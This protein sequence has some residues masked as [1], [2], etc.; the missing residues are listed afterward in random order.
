MFALEM[1]SPIAVT[2]TTEVG[3]GWGGVDPK[4][5]RRLGR[6]PYN[7]RLLPKA[8]GKDTAPGAGARIL[9]KLVC[10]WKVQVPNGSRLTLGSLPFLE[11]SCSDRGSKKKCDSVFCGCPECVGED[12]KFSQ[13]WSTHRMR[14]NEKKSKGLKE[15]TVDVELKPQTS[16]SNFSPCFQGLWIERS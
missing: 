4:L 3:R 14:L 2:E 11:G 16:F 6:Q 12:R 7:L 15:K 1:L 8:S 5:G 13:A 10:F 9:K